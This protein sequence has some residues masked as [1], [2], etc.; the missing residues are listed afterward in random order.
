MEGTR[1]CFALIK[2]NPEAT[3][4]KAESIEKKALKADIPEPEIQAIMVQCIY[5]RERNDFERMMSKA[6]LLYKKASSYDSDVYRLMARRY[7]F[8]AYIFSGLPEK[9]FQELEKGSRL[10]DKLD[11]NDSLH[12]IGRSDFFIAFSN[13]Y[14]QKGNFQNQLKYLKLAG[15]EFERMPNQMYRKELLY[16]HYSNLATTYNEL[17]RLDSAKYYT[18]LSESYNINFN[19]NDTNVNN[20]WVFG[21]V[22][23]KEERYREA[24]HYFREA[25]KLED[26]TNHL[27]VESLYDKIIYSYKKLSKEDSAKIYEAKKDSLK[28]S[29]T[30]SQNKSLQKLLKEKDNLTNQY[31]IYALAV[32]ILVLGTVAFIVV[33]KSR[34]LV[35]QE[36]K[37]QKYLADFSEN[38]NLKIYNQLLE[39]LEEANPA[40]MNYFDEIFPKFA[41]NLLKVNPR[42]IQ[43]EIEFCSLLKLKIPTKDIARYKFITPKTVQNKKYLIRKKLNIPKDV[44]IYQWFDSM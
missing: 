13:Y 37:S 39:M 28:L 40:Y 27:N 14:S 15:E 21:N 33:R 2:T 6:K 32:L 7:L 19:R 8:E 29:I 5:F 18:T 23:L 42:I 4:K 10:I 16:I 1:T 31:L 34:L 11:K 44:D 25:E 35:K 36:M 30:V 12:I 38:H 22:A 9:A 17:N 26:Y 3:F 24:L 41:S 20:L 43:S